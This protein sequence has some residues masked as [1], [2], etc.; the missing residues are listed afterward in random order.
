MSISTRSRGFSLI[1]LLLVLAIIGIISGVAIPSFMGQRKRA[2]VIG[3][4]RA[5]ANVLGMMLEARK[6]ETGLYGAAGTNQTWTASGSM[7][8]ASTSLVP[9]FVAR[10]NS[11]MNFNVLVGSGGLTYTLLITDPS[12][13][14]HTVLTGTQSGALTVSST[15]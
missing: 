4:A 2:R 14:G 5:N 12:R 7:P 15:Y 8:S 11:Q 1:E 13:G 6:A 10:G 9:A 3:D